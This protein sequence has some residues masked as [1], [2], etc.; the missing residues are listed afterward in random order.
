ML[1][2]TV[3]PGESSGDME[4]LYRSIIDVAGAVPAPMVMYSASPALQAIQAQL[5]AYYQNHPGLT[6]LLKTLI[7]YLTALGLEMEPCVEFN[8]NLLKAQ[9]MTDEQIDELK[10]NPAAAPLNEKEGWLLAF[11][12]K[13][14]R[15]PESVSEGYIEKLRALGWSDSDVFDALNMATTML[16]SA[17]MMEVLKFREA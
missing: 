7:R 17:T 8:A 4:D 15:S 6:P 2:K 16:G 12:I 5:L 14:V 9:G 11:V 10:F 13:A 1:L 3:A